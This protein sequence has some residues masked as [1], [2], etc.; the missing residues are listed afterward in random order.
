MNR[1]ISQDFEPYIDEIT[2]IC[3]QVSKDIILNAKKIGLVENHDWEGFTDP[4]FL[5]NIKDDIPNSPF[6]YYVDFGGSITNKF[7]HILQKVYPDYNIHDS[8]YYYYPPTG[9]MGWHTNS[10]RPGKRLY[11]TWSD[12]DSS[13]RFLQD[14]EVQEDPD[15]VNSP[16][17][18][19]FDIP[20][21]P[22]KFWHCVRSENANRLSFGFRLEKK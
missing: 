12:G 9:Y 1:N 19:E 4:S 14:N 20:E 11:I 13:F 7:M 17:I 18:R 15:N 22:D 10:N 6:S 8:G 3:K 5:H 16:T 21:P 2:D